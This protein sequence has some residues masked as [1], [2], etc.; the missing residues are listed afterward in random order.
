[1]NQRFNINRAEN[2]INQFSKTLD[3][4]LV[5][6]SILTE[7]GT[8]LYSFMPIIPLMAGAKKVMAWTQDSIYGSAESAIHQCRNI[9]ASTDNTEIDFHVGPL[10][11]DHL[12][13]A[14]V[15]TNSAFLRPLDKEKLK[16]TKCG[17]VIPLMYEKWEFRASDI[18]IEY[19]RKRGIKVAGTN[20]RHPLLQIFQYVG[21][22][23]IKMVFEAGYEVYKNK[24]VIWSNDVFGDV[25][26]NAFKSLNA[27][28]IIKTT[29]FNDVRHSI[30]GVDFIFIA[31]YNEV[32]SYSDNSFF[33]LSELKSINQ[34]FGVVHLYGSIDFE[35]VV[36]LN[37]PIFPRKN[38]F[39]RKMSFTLSHLG[40][41]PF[42]GLQV[43]CF[44]VGEMLLSGNVDNDLSQLICS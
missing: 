30:G 8:G 20:E 32:R 17:V 11:V 37:I 44:K 18:D 31:D 19:C 1:M 5:G 6:Y 38:G 43:G 7:V 4:S 16:H 41:V 35:Q 2:I 26:F 3:L 23:A 21:P 15:I 42:L 27:R 36:N 29:N 9:L 40:L 22:L 14:D 24:I 39:A 33:N 13:Q 25:I 12:K 34:D 10:N 28:E